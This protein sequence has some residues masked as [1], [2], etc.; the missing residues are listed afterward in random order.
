MNPMQL[1]LLQEENVLLAYLFSIPSFSLEPILIQ[2][3][4][5][6]AHH[7]I[8]EDLLV[9]ISEFRPAY[10]YVRDIFYKRDSSFQLK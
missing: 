7:M 3:G 9:R 10:V 8:G 6:G 4:G 5:G 1:L 2:C